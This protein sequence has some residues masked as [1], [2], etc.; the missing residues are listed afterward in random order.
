MQA[1]S[2][3]ALA[4][5]TTDEVTGVE[6]LSR[7]CERSVRELRGSPPLPLFILDKPV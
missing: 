5:K 7:T 2:A 3:G 1:R 4:L 6:A